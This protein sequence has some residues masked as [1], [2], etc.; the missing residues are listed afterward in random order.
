MDLEFLNGKSLFV[1]PRA[2]LIVACL[3]LGA[4]GAADDSSSLPSAGASAPA[5]VGPTEKAV[6][7][8]AGPPIYRFAK[9]STGAYFYTGSESEK[10]QIIRTLS[11]FRYEGSPFGMSTGIGSSDVYRFANLGNGAYFYT[12]SAAERDYVIANLKATYRYEGT[13]FAVEQGPGVGSL[14]TYRMANLFNGAYLYPTSRSE[15]DAAVA[16]GRWREEGYAFSARPSTLEEC[17]VGRDGTTLFFSRCRDL[18]KLTFT[19]GVLVGNGFDAAF[20]NVGACTVRLFSNGDISLTVQGRT[21][22]S[23]LDASTDGDFLTLES[24]GRDSTLFADDP[25]TGSSITIGRVGDAVIAFY[26]PSTAEFRMQSGCSGVLLKSMD[27]ASALPKSVEAESS[28]PP[29]LRRILE[30]IEGQRRFER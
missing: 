22:S 12:A 25:L 17:V 11:D 16:T 5:M 7:P 30:R 1:T 14:A 15:V 10:D 29:D 26:Y 3:A 9:I 2:A 19:D 24:N 18:S 6:P 21:F 28:A 4:C 20:Q 8:N 23:R 27:N 13:S